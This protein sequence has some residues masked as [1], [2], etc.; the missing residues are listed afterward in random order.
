ME[1]VTFCFPHEDYRREHLNFHISQ[2]A[3]SKQYLLGLNPKYEGKKLDS[4]SC[5]RENVP[6]NL[7]NKKNMPLYASRGSGRKRSPK[8]EEQGTK[9]QYSVNTRKRLEV[10]EEKQL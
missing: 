6:F 1:K 2:C 5:V 4:Y 9:L 3:K 7:E 10:R 8:G